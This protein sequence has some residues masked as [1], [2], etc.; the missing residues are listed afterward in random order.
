[1]VFI[2]APTLMHIPPFSY[3]YDKMRRYEDDALGMKFDD[4][5]DD[6]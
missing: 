1:M 3:V 4:D 6:V 5:D 2:V